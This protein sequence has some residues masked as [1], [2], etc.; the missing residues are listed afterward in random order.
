MD[1]EEAVCLWLLRK[2]WK[3]CKQRET[4][5][6]WV[7]PILRDRLTH[8]IFVSLY[9]KLREYDA[10]FYSYFRMSIK[11]FGDLLGLINEDIS[12]CK[13]YV[14]DYVS[15]GEKPVITPRY[16]ASECSFA[17]LHYAYRLG[18][19]TIIEIVHEVCRAIWKKL[20]T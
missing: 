20:K 14:R 15:P 12:S 9:P 4:R 5:R 18:K 19:S 6:Y 8:G 7:H 11:S 13:C 10:K 17:D 16:L 1:V 2:I 3:R